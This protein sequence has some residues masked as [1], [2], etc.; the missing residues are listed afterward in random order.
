MNLLRKQWNLLELY[1]DNSLSFTQIL[2]NA[3]HHRNL[4]NQ[5]E[6]SLYNIKSDESVKFHDPFLFR[7]MKKAV[8]RIMRAINNKEKVIIYGDYDV[9]GITASA[10]LLIFFKN[11]S[12]DYDYYIPNRL[13]E[14]YGLSE[15]GIQYILDNN[16]S[17]VIT[18]DCG[19]TGHK[20]IEI[21][22]DHNIDCILTDHHQEGESLPMPYAMINP[23][24]K[25]CTYPFRY[26]CGA[27]VA[28]KLVQALCQVMNLPD[29][30][31]QE[32]LDIASLGTISDVMPL[33]GENRNIVK[34]GLENINR[35]RMRI[36]LKAM[37]EQCLNQKNINKD[38]DASNIGFVFGPRI[39]AA[40]R[41]GQADIA[42]KLLLCDC[43]KDAKYYCKKLEELNEQRRELEKIA[44]DEALS[45]ILDKEGLENKQ[46]LII[47]SPNLHQ[48][49]LGII[50]A[51][52]GQKYLRPVIVLAK[53]KDDNDDNNQTILKGS[54]RSFGNI[55]ILSLIKEASKDD[56]GNDL[57]L[58]VGGH[59]HAAGLSIAEDK[60]AVFAKKI[61]TLASL[62]NLQFE[63]P[64]L[65]IDFNLFFKQIN[66]EN[67]YLLKDFGPYGHNHPEFVFLAKNLILHDFTLVGS[68]KK[69]LQ[70]KLSDSRKSA[71]INAIA[72]NFAYYQNILQKGQHL[73][74]VFKLNVNEWNSNTSVQMMVE[75]IN[76]L[77]L[78]AEEST[79]ESF[80]HTLIYDQQCLIG[81]KNIF[82]QKIRSS[83]NQY[84]FFAD[85]YNFLFSLCEDK[86]KGV[87]I[88]E[89]SELARMQAWLWQCPKS[90]NLAR[91]SLR[92]FEQTDVLKIY[93]WSLKPEVYLL[94]FKKPQNKK[95]ISETTAFQSLINECEGLWT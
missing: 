20:E 44:S 25:I 42:L 35:Q 1:T 82:L 70:M 62:D 86:D 12:L 29:E 8:D 27:G 31:W 94:Q 40:G 23:S 9:D 65:N 6:Q 80:E 2:E 85:L 19:I 28:L 21:L 36:G 64:V 48:G 18:V 84:K 3:C 7:D 92:I 71:L 51:K 52:L 87:I 77:D 22:K 5:E 90:E 4:R 11:L 63:R 95:K 75:D 79:E 39:N 72:F 33:I 74:I 34:L 68:N 10:I 83:K 91:R 32:F 14:G 15:H 50:A 55:D 93:N 13:E 76:I 49:I 57:V 56:E 69:H 54:A 43:F 88:V 30:K 58:E 41:M 47:Y 37:Y 78:C 38:I 59:F 46:I 81:K 67:A 26:L 17:L 16:Y 89:L 61:N 66:L 53:N 45:I 24:C 60:L 73:D